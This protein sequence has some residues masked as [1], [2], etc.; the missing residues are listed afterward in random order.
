VSVYEP[1]PHAK[2][3]VYALVAVA[4]ERLPNRWV[5]APLKFCHAATHEVEFGVGAP[6][7]G[8]RAT[9]L[10]LAVRACHTAH[11]AQALPLSRDELGALLRAVTAH[12]APGHDA[13]DLA[14][15]ELP[16][17]SQHGPYLG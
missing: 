5:G 10:L 16:A 17:P 9:A 13:A 4:E 14:T 11:A 1:E 8:R 3:L 2:P 6:I 15:R 12:A 7:G